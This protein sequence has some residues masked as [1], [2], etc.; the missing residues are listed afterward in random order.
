[1]MERV[2]LTLEGMTCDHCVRAVNQALRSV[3][4]I[5]VEQVEV[6]SAIVA[7][8]P[9]AVKLEKIREVI[10]GEGFE[11]RSMGRAT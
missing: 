2:S 4:G 3:P 9:A 10:S 8:D 7:Y 6:G 11:V 1:M 5:Q